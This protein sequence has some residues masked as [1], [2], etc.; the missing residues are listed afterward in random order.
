[1]RSWQEILLFVSLGGLLGACAQSTPPADRGASDQEPRYGGLL[2]ISGSADAPTLDM[3]ASTTF[4]TSLPVQPSTNP[5]VR[6]DPLDPK[7]FKVEPNLAERWE[8]SPDGKTYTFHLKQG[9]KFH[10]GGEFTASD[11]KF[12]YERQIQVVPGQVRPRR[13]AFDP[14]DR[15]EVV[16]DYTLRMVMKRPYAALL[17]NLAQGWMAMYDKEWAEAG[18]DPEKEV[19]GTG[20]FVF[21]EYVRGAYSESIRNPNYWKEGMPYLD[22]VKYF[23][24]PDANTERAACRTGNIHMCSLPL[25]EQQSFKDV[26][27]DKMRFKKAEY[28]LGSHL[29]NMSTLKKPFDDVRVRYALAY[30]IDAEAAIKLLHEGQ[31]YTAAFMDSNGS[32][33]LPREE[34]AK[35]P[36]F[37]PDVAKNRTEAKR[38]LAEAG[39]PD[40]FKV[41]MGVRQ[42]SGVEE[43]AIFLKDQFERIGV[44]ATLRTIETAEAYAM[45]EK[46]DYQVFPWATT[47]AALDDPDAVYAEHLTCAAPRNYQKLCIPEVDALFAKQSEELDPV[48]RRQLVNEMEKAALKMMPKIPMPRGSGSVIGVWNTV[49]NWEPQPTNFNNRNWEQAWLAQ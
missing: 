32:W 15:I 21:K 47:L 34:L 23:V 42:I 3:H 30:A 10:Q 31:G 7:M 38:L 28:S 8:V 9:V 12:S 11:A 39:Y 13:A 18:H 35:L 29:V 2:N 49:W 44:S 48:K 37:G 43:Y 22:G 26:L 17:P 5:L 33:G 46:G 25:R 41:T 19:N 36:G 16:D 45:L 14:V 4:A 6:Y 24:I 27:G 20:P 1:M 40:G